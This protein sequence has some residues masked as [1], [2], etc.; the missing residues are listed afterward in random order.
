M[1][2]SLLYRLYKDYAMPRDVKVLNTLR[3]I[4]QLDAV[5]LNA[6]IGNR[7]R[8]LSGY[9]L[10]VQK[11][12]AIFLSNSLTDPLDPDSGGG[13]LSE[14]GG[15]ATFHSLADFQAKAQLAADKTNQEIYLSQIEDGIDDEQEIL[16]IASIV[17][18]IQG[19]IDDVSQDTI[20]GFTITI[21]IRNEAGIS[22][23]FA[24]EIN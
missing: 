12:V 17:S 7:S 8:S 19:V 2:C 15:N 9:E 24:L 22:G 21:N 6:N 16:S 20:D 1:E 3:Y 5:V 14:I 4:D 18:V 11:W 10:L 13:M 23:D